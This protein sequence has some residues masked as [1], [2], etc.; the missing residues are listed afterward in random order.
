MPAFLKR[1]LLVLLL[2]GTAIITHAQEKFVPGDILVM[3]RPGVSPMDV[4]KDLQTVNNV[5]TSVHAVKEISA[6][7]RAWLFR[8]D[9]ATLPQAAMLRAFQADAG[10]EMAQNNHIGK[11]RS[12]PNDPSYAL[13]WQHQNIDSEGAW[14][15]T[16]GG[17]TAS[18]DTIVVAIIENADLVHP[19]LAANA[20][21]NIHEIADNGIDD[22]DTGYIDDVRGWNPGTGNDNVY[23]GP[24]GTEV[25]GMIGAV[26]N[27]GLQVVGANWHVKMM[28]VQYA[29][30][31]ESDVIAA[32]TYPLVMRRLY[33]STAGA[34]GAFVVAT[35]ASWGVD[36]GQ[37]SS[38]PLWCAMYDTLGTAGILN[39]GA[40][41]NNNVDVDVVGDLPTA[42][43]SDF[44]ISVTATN[45]DDQRTFSGYG[46]TTIDVGAPGQNVVT[47][48]LGGGIATTSGT[49]FASPL[50]AGV[51]ALLYSVP[52]PS[53][54][55]RVQSEPAQAAL[56]VRQALF[57]GVDQVG[58][59]PG[60]TVTGGRI[61]A[62]NSV[63]IILDSCVSCPAPYIAGVNSNAI[64]AATVGWNAL[65]GIYNLR[66]RLVGA[67][68][69][70]EVDGLT[71][72]SLALSGLS[73]CEPYEFQMSADCDTSSSGF[74]PS[75]L[76]TSEGCCTAPLTITATSSD[77]S[78][79]MVHWSTVLASGA[80]DLRHREIG[81]TDWTEMDDLTGNDVTLNGLPACSDH[82]VQMRSSCG[83]TTADW[84]PSTTFHVAGCGQCI[85]GS[86]CSSSGDDEFEWI[87][88][89][90]IAGI[91]RTS[92]GDGGYADIDVTG[93]STELE[94][95][96]SY[97]ITLTPGY[98]GDPFPEYFT[99][100]MDLNR[101]GEFAANELVFDPGASV[102]VPVVSTLTVP[103][104]ATP[105]PARMRV[106]MRYSLPVPDGCTSY[107]FGETEDYCVSLVTTPSGIAENAA[108]TAVKVYPQPANDVV[109]FITGSTGNEELRV[110]DAS[111]RL[112]LDLPVSN[113]LIALPT[114]DLSDG[115]YIYRIRS[116]GV[117]RAR[118]T[119]MVVH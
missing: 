29:S 97:P 104:T 115:L 68:D 62:N 114:Q 112:L 49:S 14:D 51:I 117:D 66:Y 43:P 44:M 56:Q 22:D 77:T 5:A 116:K 92:A 38:A 84:S 19:D 36:G 45:S 78:S 101:D 73:V 88:G 59:L 27:N 34:D 3:L 21:H 95:G 11:E 33:N 69:W 89:V 25:A 74:G 41:A 70:T 72:T 10:I 98:D 61:N 79:A 42:C 99:V 64:D 81:T 7:M 53:F 32:Y 54:A 82:E 67:A 63:Q 40:T 48:A 52:C 58:N 13:Q 30:A 6:P 17:L 1:T 113:G 102:M 28:P 118:G 18:G 110:M 39:C 86:F 91:D 23:G 24:H 12:I 26:G 119:F 76:W 57:D 96:S 65:P 71:G 83:A 103:I 87:A 107:D 85:E 50:T 100:W 37:P 8:F 15:V 35:N 2:T 108:I 94:I 93:E 60:Q 55:L 46:L 80:Y 47:T 105:G 109:N 111:G 20:W 75:F 90:Q 16:T 31:V 9:P 106:V 4:A